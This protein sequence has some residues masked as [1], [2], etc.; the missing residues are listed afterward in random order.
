MRCSIWL[1]KPK[2]ARL[3]AATLHH[4][5]N[6]ARAV[7]L[8]GRLISMVANHKLPPQS[9]CLARTSAALILKRGHRFP[10]VFS[11]ALLTHSRDERE[12]GNK[13][14]QDRRSSPLPPD[15][16][17]ANQNASGSQPV[18]KP[19]ISDIRKWRI[20][21]QSTSHFAPL[22]NR[23]NLPVHSSW[24]RNGWPSPQALPSSGHALATATPTFSLCGAIECVAEVD[25]ADHRIALAI[26]KE[27]DIIVAF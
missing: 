17:P 15:T 25:A 4:G 18:K 11:S 9:D 22:L 21:P 6:L 26:K 14:A 8:T 19:C 12:D 27:K 2:D 23:L 16:P 13:S 7:D 10:S 20:T 1:V 24:T 3:S 5:P